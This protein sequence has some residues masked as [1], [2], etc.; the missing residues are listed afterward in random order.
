MHSARSASANDPEPDFTGAA[1][2]TG[3]TSTKGFPYVTYPEGQVF[4]WQKRTKDSLVKKAAELHAT[5]PWLSLI[6]GV[7]CM[8]FVFGAAVMYV[9]FSHAAAI[10]QQMGVAAEVAAALNTNSLS[11]QHTLGNVFC[12]LL[13]HVTQIYGSFVG[14]IMHEYEGWQIAAFRN[15][16]VAR[17][18]YNPHAYNN[19]W[20]RAVVYRLLFAVQTAG[21]LCYSVG[22]F[23]PYIGLLPPH[24]QGVR[25]LLTLAAAASLVV[26]FVGPRL[27]PKEPMLINGQPVMPIPT[28]LELAFVANSIVNMFAN[29]VVFHALGAQVQ[30]YIAAGLGASTPLLTLLALAVV[31]GAVAAVRLFPKT[32]SGLVAAIALVCAVAVN[33]YGA[34]LMACVTF[35]LAFL[36]INAPALCVMGGGTLEGLV[37]E[38]GFDQFWHFVT[39]FFMHASQAVYVIL[40]LM[41][42][43]SQQVSAWKWAFAVY[44]GLYSLAIV[45]VLVEP[46]IKAAAAWFKPA[47]GSK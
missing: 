9:V 7:H 8:T 33:A 44:F 1:D 41:L 2:L 3:S 30:A 14:I 18:G 34:S 20:L 40:Y 4:G 12:L 27:Y 11:Q 46:F 39:F 16:L 29:F 35:P 19:A 13:A 42:V 28:P 23:A 5:P 22:A 45:A 37:A 36:L 6:E 15:P 21:L 31:F 24:L 38:S 17:D 10:A 47:K 26:A 25:C 43:G 32:G